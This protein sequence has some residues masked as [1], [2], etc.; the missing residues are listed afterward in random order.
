MC[1]RKGQVLKTNALG[2]ENFVLSYQQ[3][4]AKKSNPIVANEEQNQQGNLDYN[5]SMNP[6]Y[7]TFSKSGEFKSNLS[8]K[9][10]STLIP[11]SISGKY[12]DRKYAIRTYRYV[13][14]RYSTRGDESIGTGLT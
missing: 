5:Y 10:T 7:R 6:L 2:Y 11:N 8:K 3:S 14:P 13:D 9:S 12:L 1:E 4:H